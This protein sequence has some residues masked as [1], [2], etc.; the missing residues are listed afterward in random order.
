MASNNRLKQ[1]APGRSQSS[2]IR[3]LIDSDP[4]ICWQAM[5][6]LTDAP[7]DEVGAERARVATALRVLDWF[8]GARDV[9]REPQETRGTE[10]RSIMRKSGSPKGTS[11]S[12][13]ID[14]R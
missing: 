14:E 1:T 11:P 2:V 9:R 8:G 6:D 13:M 5:R 10:E 4:S 7:A 3:W 12:R